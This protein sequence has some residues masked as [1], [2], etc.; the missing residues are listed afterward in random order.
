MGLV[1][2]T[3]RALATQ[4]VSTKYYPD[5]AGVYDSAADGFDL[6]GMDGGAADISVQ[7]FVDGHAS[8]T[9]DIDIEWSNDRLKW[10][11]S[12]SFTQVTSSDSVQI[13]R[14]AFNCRYVRLKSVV[15]TATSDG[16]RAN[17]CFPSASG[18]YSA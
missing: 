13:K 4:V 2:Q 6:S 11:K 17:I 15:G 18:A 1:V 3:L 8:S 14:P 10:L 9:V 12:D 7:I 16:W 5:S